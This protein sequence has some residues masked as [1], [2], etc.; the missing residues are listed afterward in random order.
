MT[1]D[2]TSIFEPIFVGRSHSWLLTLNTRLSYELIKLSDSASLA[3]LVSQF[4]TGISQSGSSGRREL[5]LNKFI[6]LTAATGVFD[7]IIP[8]SYTHLT[9]P[10]K[11]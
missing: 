7:D 1:V 9:L 3:L 8:V 5:S 6:F 11:A 10:T 4:C 2:R